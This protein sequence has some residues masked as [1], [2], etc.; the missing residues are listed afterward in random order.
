MIITLFLHD[1]DYWA[2]ACLKLKLFN[3]MYSVAHAHL[4][5]RR[6][7]TEC[8]LLKISFLKL[9]QTEWA[10]VSSSYITFRIVNESA[11]APLEFVGQPHVMF[12][13][14][15]VRAGGALMED[16]TKHNRL[17]EQMYALHGKQ[18]RLNSAMYGMSTV[19]AGANLFESLDHK[20]IA[21]PAGGSARVCMTLP[22]SSV[23]W[24]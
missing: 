20:P 21:I 11:T 14:M 1:L 13:R 15:Q 22:V 12:N 17:C 5:C 23:F 6:I 24:G 10:D 2:I 4:A 19:M 7:S 8:L 18:T 9:S 3:M 16:I